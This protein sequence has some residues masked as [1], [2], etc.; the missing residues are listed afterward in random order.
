MCADKSIPIVLVH[1]IARFDILHELLK[2]KLSLPENEL[3]DQFEY[4]KGI[5]SH[6][7]SDGFKVFHTNQD[8]A[9]AVDLRAQ[10]LKS[11]IEEILAAQ[12]VDR[13]HLI[14]HSMG[15]L[16]ARRMIVDLGMADRIQSLTTI[17]GPHLGT[18]LADHVLDGKTGGFLAKILDQV[19]DIEG[20]EDL[21][22]TRC[23][24]F[25]ERAEDAEAKNGVFYQTYASSEEVKMVFLPLIPS[26]MFIHEQKGRN[27]G[28][29]DIASQLWKKELVA[30]D[31]TRKEIVQKEFPFPADHLNEIGWWDP[32]E[33]LNPILGFPNLIK[34]AGEYE[35]K[36]KDVYLDIARNLP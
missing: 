29:V 4:F 7:E 24:A 36:V 22:V 13:V 6:L 17:G 23:Q 19:I 12:G 31:G 21:R 28:L 25:N 5:K 26:W 15:A 8:F 10:Q 9:G 20:F 27:D 16:D 18:V 32:G 2:E 1:G 14:T 30:G 35:R 3:E 34:Q 11:R 33:A